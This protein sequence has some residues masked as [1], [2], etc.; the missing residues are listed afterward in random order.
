M[1]VAMVR[2]GLLVTRCARRG[3]L[4]AVGGNDGYNTVSVEMRTMT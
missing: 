2:V 3:R 1:T 4:P